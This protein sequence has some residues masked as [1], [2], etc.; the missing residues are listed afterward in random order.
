MF[1]RYNVVA[2]SLANFARARDNPGGYAEKNCIDL[3]KE[4]NMPQKT[5]LLIGALSA[6]LTLP[7]WAADAASPSPVTA[8]VSIVNNYLYR[9]ISRTDGSPAVQGGIDL[10]A[11]NGLY[12]GA[13]GSNVSWLIDRGM[14]ASSSVELD[15]YAGLK[16]SFAIDFSYDLGILRYHY[17]AIYNVGAVNADTNELYASLGYE[18]LVAKYSYSQGNAFGI[19]GS[20]GTDYIDISANYPVSDSG[21]TLGAHYGKQAYKGVTANAMKA[22][23]QD[24]SYADYRVNISKD[25]NGYVFGVAYSKTNTTKGSGYYNVL[26]RDLGRTAAVFSLRHTF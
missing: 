26:G 15:V 24:P 3:E 12:V 16:N 1:F 21:I 23:G 6:L 17:P 7:A 19:E 13:W 14:A 18:W 5:S 10:I 25:W 8:N 20:K 4:L 22:A 2:R 9:G 11:S